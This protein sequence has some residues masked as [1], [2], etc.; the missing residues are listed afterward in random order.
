LEPPETHLL[1]VDQGVG[2]TSTENQLCE[3][4]PSVNNASDNVLATH[5]K[6]DVEKQQMP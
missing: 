4:E 2:F 3:L 1:L 5:F 6:G